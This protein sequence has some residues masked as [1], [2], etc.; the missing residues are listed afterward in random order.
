[1]GTPPPVQSRD[2]QTPVK[3]QMGNTLGPVGLWCYKCVWPPED[4]AAGQRL[5]PIGTASSPKP[6]TGVG[7]DVGK[8]EP[9]CTVGGNAKWCQ[10]VN[11][12][13]KQY[14]GSSKD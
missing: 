2:W 5:P 10:T 8:L 14:A 6:Q 1:M 9:L 12:H 4:K 11:H 7:G 3:G 13:G